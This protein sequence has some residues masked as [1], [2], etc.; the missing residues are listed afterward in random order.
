MF[1]LRTADLVRGVGKGIKNDRFPSV[2]VEG[3]RFYVIVQLKSKVMR[4]A[5][6]REPS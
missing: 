1:C 3:D 4:Y 6:R 5:N 2:L